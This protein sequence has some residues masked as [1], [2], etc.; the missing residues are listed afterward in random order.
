MRMVQN[1]GRKSWATWQ[2]TEA[3]RERKP[4]ISGVHWPN[5]FPECVYVT[6]ITELCHCK[7]LRNKLLLKLPTHVF[8]EWFG[9][10]QAR[11]TEVIF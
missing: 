9:G 7:I 8:Y 10:K 4:E 1:R 11:L 2:K 3:I 5:I 6:F